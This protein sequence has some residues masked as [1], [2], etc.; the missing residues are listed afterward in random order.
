MSL[1][2]H[3]PMSMMVLMILIVEN[4]KG[5]QSTWIRVMEVEWIQEAAPPEM[6]I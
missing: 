3:M 4:I 6:R 1:K 5:F 2:A